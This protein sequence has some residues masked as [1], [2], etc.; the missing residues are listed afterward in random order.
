MAAH[1]GVVD[2]AQIDDMSYSFFEDVLEELGHRLNYEAIVN[3]A[4]NTFCEKSWQ[5]ISE[6]NPFNVTGKEHEG[7]KA[8]HSLADFF[9]KSE[10]KMKGKGA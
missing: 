3:Y 9:G 1:L 7:A 4:G 5:M 6:N 8:M 10:I 2:E